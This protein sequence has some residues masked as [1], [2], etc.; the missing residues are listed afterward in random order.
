[1]SQKKMN[2]WDQ[3]FT[4]QAPEAGEAS[5]EENV[6]DFTNPVPSQEQERHVR[7]ILFSEAGVVSELEKDSEPVTAEAMDAVVTNMITAEDNALEQNSAENDD[8]EFLG[9]R[10][11]S[12]SYVSVGFD[13]FGISENKKAENV[14]DATADIVGE[15][16]EGAEDT[17]NTEE[18][19]SECVMDVESEADERGSACSWDCVECTEEETGMEASEE[20]APILAEDGALRVTLNRYERPAN[21]F[22]F[23]LLEGEIVEFDAV[24]DSP[25]EG[26]SLEEADCE[27]EMVSEV[28]EE[29]VSETPSGLDSWGS[30]AF[31]LG[32][33]V[34]LPKCAT[35]K[36]EKVERTMKTP[37]SEK[38]VK[39]E[40]FEKSEK[41]GNGAHGEKSEKGEKSTSKSGRKNKVENVEKAPVVLE[42]EDFVMPENVF[43][44]TDCVGERAERALRQERLERSMRGERRSRHERGGWNRWEERDGEQAEA[45]VLPIMPSEAEA[46][47]MED[48]PM[49]SRRRRRGNVSAEVSVNEEKS[50]TIG[51]IMAGVVASKMNS[52][53]PEKASRKSRGSRVEREMYEEEVEMEMPTR[54]ERSRRGRCN[55]AEMEE[56]VVAH[57]FCMRH[58][59]ECPTCMAAYMAEEKEEDEIEM[60][61]GARSRRRRR[62]Q[63]EKLE[64]T[65]MQEKPSVSEEDNEDEMEDISVRKRSRRDSRKVFQGR[66]EIED[67]EL[68]A[69][70]V[71]AVDDM[72]DEEDYDAPRSRRQRRSRRSGREE[73]HENRRGYKG[74][75][76]RY[77]HLME[78]DEEHVFTEV[79]NDE[80]DEDDDEW[81]TDFSQHEVPSWRYTIDFIV[82]TNLKAR[83][84]EPSSMAGNV[85]RGNNKRP[86]RK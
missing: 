47:A 8:S 67:D 14:E 33:P 37:K 41:S 45:M 16:E 15:A 73:F 51:E 32:L 78:D 84:R 71:Q 40:S 83:K 48:V 3:I 55:V 80:E 42:G 63:R 86:R 12:K 50:A 79:C 60:P 75:D 57:E 68:G 28:T 24:D 1:M 70:N 11:T 6:L 19:A 61:N 49:R 58:D 39:S 81:E 77:G 65:R 4:N 66:M 43:G 23:G 74:E 26:E 64:R 7:E 36:V 62:S 34:T 46:T 38:S 82:N 30:L 25:E 20:C 18:C 17:E 52:A 29:L 10:V 72:E 35:E 76:T 9:W 56:E 22:G 21:G 31:E 59:E 69:W 5:K 54:R 27:A 13:G 44:A 53:L 85:N 2:Y